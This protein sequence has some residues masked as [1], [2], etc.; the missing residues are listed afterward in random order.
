MPPS[1]VMSPVITSR[2]G[3]QRYQA[4]PKLHQRQ[5]RCDALEKTA[6]LASTLSQSH[7]QGKSRM[8]VDT[9][10]HEQV[11]CHTA[12]SF[13]ASSTIRA[14]RLPSRVSTDDHSMQRQALPLLATLPTEDAKGNNRS[15][16]IIIHTAAAIH[17]LSK[18]PRSS[19]PEPSQTY[20]Q[21]T[22]TMIRKVNMS[23]NPQTW[24]LPEIPTLGY[25]PHSPSDLGPIEDIHRCTH[26]ETASLDITQII[27]ER[28]RRSS[29]NNDA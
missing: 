25:T 2:R 23:S 9:N 14:R 19:P 11:C 24:T 28:S 18:D 17:S 1:Q 5:M 10:K 29:N 26:Q 13:S 22:Q 3:G 20:K 7:V 16:K 6:N 15:A 21:N 12:C 4:F 8:I 27:V